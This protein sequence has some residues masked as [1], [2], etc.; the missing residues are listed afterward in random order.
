MSHFSGA[1]RHRFGLSPSDLRD[2]VRFARVV[3]NAARSVQVRG[4]ESYEEWLRRLGRQDSMVAQATM[5]R[6]SESISA[7]YAL[8]NRAR[9]APSPI[10]SVYALRKTTASPLS[11]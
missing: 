2:T 9:E 8:G 10:P 6:V 7:N 11:S 4:V 5:H 1:F 3:G